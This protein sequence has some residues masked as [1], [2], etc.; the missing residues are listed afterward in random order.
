MLSF[1][2]KMPSNNTY[3]NMRSSKKI[4]HFKSCLTFVLATLLLSACDNGPVKTISKK[5][6][7]VS[8]IQSID[9]LV[10]PYDYTS[11]ISLA[12]L[13]VDEK[14]QKFVAMI[15]PAILTVRA[16]LKNRQNE[17]RALISS[18]TSVLPKDDKLFLKELLKK[19]QSENFDQL[20]SKLNTHPN[21]IVLAQSAVESG[22]G[23][24]RF[25]LEANNVFGVW[26]FNE[27]DDRII[28][29]S[30]RDGKYTY[31][32]RY[33]SLSKS[34]E[35]YFLTISNGPYSDFRRQRKEV[36]NPYVLVN[37]LLKYSELRGY[38]VKKLQLII[39]V[40]DFTKY[41]NYQIDPK[42]LKKDSLSNQIVKENFEFEF[43]QLE[44]DV[45]DTVMH[46]IEVV[47]DSLFVEKKENKKTN[48]QN[49]KPS[50]EPNDAKRDLIKSDLPDFAAINNVK[51]KKK[52]FFTFMK[53]YISA[54]NERVLTERKFIVDMQTK[55]ISNIELSEDERAKLQEMLVRYRIKNTDLNNSKCYED[56]LLHVDIIPPE[57]ALVQA[58]LESAWGTSYFARK[59]NNIFGQWCFTPGC[60]IIPKRRPKGDTHEVAVFESVSLSV[61]YY[62]QFL[63]SH[64]LFSKL[65]KERFKNRKNDESPDALRMAGGLGAYSARGNE[66]INELR[67]MIVTNKSYMGLE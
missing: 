51:K 28:S 6:R 43:E 17:V 33:P 53:T 27:N 7:K 41:D 50:A 36:K 58:A 59:A 20:L 10:K 38:Y 60:G 19:Y 52:R 4:I 49:K 18:D 32:K 44:E 5:I 29:N 54:E 21:S 67:S 57:L 61:R 26:S 13:S 8:D 22:W 48:L 15:L 25:F 55:F 1:V 63:N 39:K 9:S 23:T 64:P 37:G 24:S 31:L 42:Y 46:D 65:R 16:E 62:L 47:E 30:D 3:I 66:Y 34:I 45:I 12:D 11:V 40:N 56:L 2:R 35:D 14:K